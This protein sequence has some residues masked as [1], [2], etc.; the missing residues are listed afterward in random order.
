M[1]IVFHIA[2]KG[3][4]LLKEYINSEIDSIEQQLHPNASHAQL[5]LQNTGQDITDTAKNGAGASSFN[6]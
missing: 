1:Q 4:D 2:M 6:K 3:P 5:L